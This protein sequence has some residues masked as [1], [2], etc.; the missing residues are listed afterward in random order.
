M[1]YSRLGSSTPGASLGTS[2]TSGESRYESLF[3]VNLEP[4]L[5]FKIVDHVGVSMSGILDIPVSGAVGS[6]ETTT[7]NGVS[8][9]NSTSESV[10]V[11][12]GGLQFGL[13]TWF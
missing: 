5:V 9:S 1:T 11:W 10:T 8:A 12:N 7:V 6:S 3:W 2:T 4:T 13:T